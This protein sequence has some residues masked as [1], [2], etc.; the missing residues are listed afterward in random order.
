VDDPEIKYGLSVTGLVHPR[1]ILSNATAKPGDQLV[2]TKP[3]GTGV[4]STA[5]K[6][7]MAADEAVKRII[8]SMVTLNLKA[9]EWMQSLGA[10][11]CTDITGFGFIG[12]ALEVAKASGVGMMISSEKIPV[13]PEAMEYARMGLIPGGA[14]ANRTFYSCHVDTDPHV[15]SLM[16][17]LLYDPQTSG[18]LLIS[19]P[20]AEAE[21]L[22]AAL[23]REGNSDA[24]IIGEV[25]ESPKGRIRVL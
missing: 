22:V 19:L 16:T 3:L 2:L 10:H 21:K 20:A 18:G 14:T 11:A 23:R 4:I 5:L 13:F 25:I 12:H 8:E 24:N 15:S 6:G 9:S 17:D 1:R 7:G